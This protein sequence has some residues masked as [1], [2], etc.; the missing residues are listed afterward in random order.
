[1]DEMQAKDEMQ[2]V[3]GNR[4]IGSSGVS[5]VAGTFFSF[6]FVLQIIIQLGYLYRKHDGDHTLLPPPPDEDP[7]R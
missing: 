4:C 2:A 3:T 6:F 7:Y 1:M 5:R